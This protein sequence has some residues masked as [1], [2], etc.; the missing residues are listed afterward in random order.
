MEAPIAKKHWHTYICII[1][2]E[3]K[4]E[5]GSSARAA[6]PPVLS[7][8]ELENKMHL[9]LHWTHTIQ[10]THS[11]PC[12]RFSATTKWKCKVES[13]WDESAIRGIKRKI[14][15]NRNGFLFLQLVRAAG[16]VTTDGSAR[17]MKQE[18]DSADD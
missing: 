10:K 5:R 2:S 4:R 13:K 12:C 8:H 6:T 14:I 11:P 18:L 1:C 15:N 7:K 16:C 17:S 3:K 9:F